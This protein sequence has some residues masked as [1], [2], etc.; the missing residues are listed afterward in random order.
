MTQGANTGAGGAFPIWRKEVRSTLVLGVPLIGA[1]M[2]QMAINFTDTLMIGWLGATELAASVIALQLFFIVFLAGLGVL[3]AVMPLASRAV[4]QNDV[5]GVRRVSRMGIWVSLIYSS[6]AMVVLWESERIFLMLGQDADVSRIGAEYLRIVQW[7]MYPGLLVIAIRCFLTSIERAGVVLWAT[8]I[9]AVLNAVLDYLLIFG[10]YGFPELGILGA[11]IA[12]VGTAFCSAAI[13]IAYV[14]IDPRSRTYEIFV[15]IWRA[16]W[17]AFFEIWRLGW[18]IS[19]TIV[20]EVGMFVA[21]AFMMGWIGKLELAAHGIAAQLSGIAFMIPLGFSQACVVRVGQAVGRQDADAVGRS[22]WVA[23][24]L[25]AVIAIFGAILFVV[26]PEPLISV[27]LDHANAESATV[28]ALA[29]PMVFVAAVYMV[30]DSIQAVGAGV[31]RGMSD[32][33]VPMLIAIMGYWVVGI[34]LSYVL[35][36]KADWG[37]VGIWWGLA[38]GLAFCSV[39]FLWRF[40]RR[41]QLGLMAS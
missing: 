3:Q 28:V 29:I 27:Y 31:L 16:D 13:L 2:A 26:T 18:A 24:V 21:A 30:F 4:G 15:R 5:R 38:S 17:E 34:G 37:P 35:A 14:Y 25:S 23:I 1:Q 32:T 10:H 41:D 20:S 33:R 19:L 6:V 12:S 11:G 39:M 40:H 8:V 22:G 7:S 36:F 9:S